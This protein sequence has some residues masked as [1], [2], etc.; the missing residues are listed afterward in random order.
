MN[1]GILTAFVIGL[2]YDGKDASL[3]LGS[4]HIAW[5]HVMLAFGI[6]PAVTQVLQCCHSQYKGHLAADADIFSAVLHTS[7]YT[8]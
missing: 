8:V 2:P 5:W 7:D 3:T 4:H 6:L 1:V